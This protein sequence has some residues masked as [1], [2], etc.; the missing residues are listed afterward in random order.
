MPELTREPIYLDNAA[1]TRP[2]A[3]VIAAV[4]EVLRVDFGNPS[5]RHGMG[6]AADKRLRTARGQVARRL[7]VQP[8]QIVFTSGGTEALALGILGTVSRRRKPGR[9]LVS[10]IEH[11]AVLNTA[12]LAERFGH[13]VDVVPV[14]GGGWVS[15]DEVA[16]RLRDDT[17]LVAV[18]HLNNEIGVVQPV[19]QIAARIKTA[20]PHC[21]FLVDAIQSVGV[22]PT[23]V[24]QLG[25][26]LLAISGH[27]I[28]APKGVGA[29]VVAPGV[30]IDALWGGGKQ[31]GGLRAGTENVPGVIGL[32]VAAELGTGSAPQL[33]ETLARLVE[34]VLAGARGA[35]V[36]GDA[37][38]RA[39]HI[40]AVG[41]PGIR[42]DVL[43]N[44]FAERGVYLSSG[45]ACHS[46]GTS[47]SHVLR[48]IGIP[49]THGVIRISPSRFLCAEDVERARQ[50]MAD[51]MAALS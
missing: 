23:V 12:R 26:D 34:P 29:L 49:E 40:A 19:E 51:V 1:T 45:S 4:N 15:P 20:L 33:E 39:P 14:T 24:S 2:A 31:E 50:V 22:Y 44:A 17:F 10:A 43:V 11:A 5:S 35:Y 16:A 6:L 8:G 28:H 32:G 30:Q 3:E 7:S 47:R 27:K 25:A 42:S 46:R 13:Q 41:L 37:E 9:L 48:A 21:I 36:I 18:M 38:R